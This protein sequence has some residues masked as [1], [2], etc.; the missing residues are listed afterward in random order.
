MNS[1]NMFQPKVV[2][3]Y[4]LSA[5]SYVSSAL[6]K[7]PRVVNNYF[8]GSSGIKHQQIKTEEAKLDASFEVRLG[9]KTPSKQSGK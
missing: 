6:H 1:K 5:K 4:Y 9:A 3:N 2:N 7:V 8:F